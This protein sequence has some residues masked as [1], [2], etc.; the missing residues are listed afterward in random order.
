MRA[1]RS[2]QV[3]HKERLVGTLAFTANQRAAFSYAADWLESGFSISP[4]SLPLKRQV[5]VPEKEYFGGLF[6][7]F[8][9]SLPDAWGNILLN[10][11]L[12]K[13]HIPADS[14]TVLDRLA[15]VGNTGMGRFP[16]TRKLC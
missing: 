3:F 4:F 13:N 5:F 1:N 14:V 7:V 15:I 9:D 16:A 10:R 12:R 11:V 6:G 8:A 2:I